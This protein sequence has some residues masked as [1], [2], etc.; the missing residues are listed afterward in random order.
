MA[1]ASDKS[2]YMKPHNI[3]YCSDLAILKRLIHVH[4]ATGVD[5]CIY[6]Y[7]VKNV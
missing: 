6:F 7:L 2:S 1:H 4:V 3:Q 5:A